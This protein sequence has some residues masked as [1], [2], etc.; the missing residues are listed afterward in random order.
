MDFKNLI[1]GMVEE[2]LIARGIRD[3][4][5]L[6]AFKKVPRHLFVL[7]EHVGSAYEDRPLPI[8]NGQTISQPYIVALML[9]QLA[10]KEDGNV[11][12]VGTGSGYEAALLAELTREV[13]TIDRIPE[14]TKKADALFKDLGYT[15]IHTKVGDGTLGWLE[16][17][18]YDAIIVSAASP[19]ILQN[20]TEQLNEGGRMIIPVGDKL[21]QALTLVEKTKGGIVSREITT[22]I[23]VPLIGRYGW[24][25]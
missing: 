24:K 25:G 4:R 6:A 7:P 22:C 11:L 23:F 1:V 2:Q 8:G 15:N 13:C 19:Q 21:T 18:P 16:H 20:L 3:E 17:S 12:E 5:V 9:E 14:L 10:L